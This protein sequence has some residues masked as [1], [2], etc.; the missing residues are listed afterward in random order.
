MPRRAAPTITLKRAVSRGVP[1]RFPYFVPAW[2]KCH[3]LP[4]GTHL[5]CRCGGYRRVPWKLQDA[6][7]FNC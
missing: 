7:F 4:Q 6:I 1:A 3:I 2:E 5:W